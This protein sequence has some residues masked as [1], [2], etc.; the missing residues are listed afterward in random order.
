MVFAG[1]PFDG[2]DA[3]RGCIGEESSIECVLVTPEAENTGDEY[4]L[5]ILAGEDVGD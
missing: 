1:G 5:F 3:F 4:V 2:E